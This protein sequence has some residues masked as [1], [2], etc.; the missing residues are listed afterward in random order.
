MIAIL[1]YGVGNVGSIKNMLKKVGQRAMIVSDASQIPEADK[2]ILPG[3]GAF[4]H[5]IRKLKEAP[6]FDY[7]EK[8]VQIEKKPVLGICIGFQLLFER[9]EEG[10]LSGLGW[11]RGDVIK[12]DKSQLATKLKV[13]HM[14][15]SDVFHENQSKLLEGLEHDPRF[16]FVHSFHPEINANDDQILSC[17]YGYKFTCGIEKEN[18]LGVQFHPEKSH[19]YGMKLLSNF[20]RNY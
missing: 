11:V 3:V 14:G 6:F 7:F 16:Y 18:I 4:D 15:W 5:G 2:F 19:K 8:A 17:K 20:A 13:P 9:S 1:D 10:E 12:F